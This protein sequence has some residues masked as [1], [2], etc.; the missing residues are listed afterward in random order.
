VTEDGGKRWNIAWAGDPN[1]RY[2]SKMDLCFVDDRAGWLVA[3]Q[4]TD[5]GPCGAI[6]GTTD[7]GAHWQ[8]LG[9]CLNVRPQRVFFPIADEGYLLA[10][11]PQQDRRRAFSVNLENGATKAEF[12]IG[13][14]S[15][16]L[17]RLTERGERTEPVMQTR[18]SLYAIS[19]TDSG[20]IA[21]CGAGGS[22]IQ[23]NESENIW[24]RKKTGTRADLND[25]GFVQQADQIA[26]LAVGEEGVILGSI[27]AGKTWSTLHHTIGRCGFSAVAMLGLSEAVVAASDAIYL[28]SAAEAPIETTK[29][30]RDG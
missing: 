12:L 10:A 7:S 4:Y 25:I 26:G 23:R 22:I 19:G 21:I 9:N 14:H 27:D 13:G 3:T 20:V 16:V 8:A 28:I 17:L 29:K 5:Q 24:E 11:T 2:G 30:L 15:S 1:A 18:S 6:F